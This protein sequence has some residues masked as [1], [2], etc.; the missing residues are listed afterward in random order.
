MRRRVCF[1]RR[2]AISGAARP[3][4]IQLLLLS[5]GAVAAS[6]VA[7]FLGSYLCASRRFDLY[8]LVSAGFGIGRAVLIVIS[9]RAGL[10]V[11]GVAWSTLGCSVALATRELL[12]GA[13]GRS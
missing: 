13:Q 8:N 3:L 11:L 12:V 4:F 6:F 7:Q 1:A 10:G 9:L 2:F 5:G